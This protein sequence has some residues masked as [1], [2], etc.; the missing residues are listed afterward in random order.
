M[1]A[2]VGAPAASILGPRRVAT[3]WTVTI[4]S[5]LQKARRGS[6]GGDTLFAV[7]NAVV[8]AAVVGHLLAWPTR[9]VLV[10]VPWLRD[11]EGLGPE[12]MPVYNPILYVSAVAGASAL[13][14]ENAEARRWPVA[15]TL[16]STPLLPALQRAE[17]RRLCRQAISERSW[18]TR[19]L[20]RRPVSLGEDD[21]GRP[22]GRSPAQPLL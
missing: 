22:S 16:A 20:A 19:R 9:R 12:L 15:A 8:V 7:S 14:A 1:A 4:S 3:L 13:L 10:C 6:H 17:F 5:A 18:W 21:P 11:C 2:G